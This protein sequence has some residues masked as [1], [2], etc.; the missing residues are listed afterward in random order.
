MTKPFDPTKPATCGGERARII[1]A[2][3]K[4]IYPLVVLI[5][6]REAAVLFHRDGTR[7]NGVPLRNIPEQEVRWLL[8][9]G[10]IYE[11]LPAADIRGAPVFKLT[12]EGGE[13]VAVELVGQSHR[14]DAHND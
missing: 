13:L 14:E 10:N 8:A 12:Y 1:C 7:D 11:S 4:G 2:D 6:K 9:Q 3:R 5:G